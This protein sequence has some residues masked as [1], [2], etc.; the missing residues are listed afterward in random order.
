MTILLVG[1]RSRPI[2]GQS[3]CFNFLVDNVSCKNY[4]VFTTGRFSSFFYLMDVI[5]ISF[6]KKIDVVYFT[7]S[8]SKL[9]F[10]RDLY[11]I[12]FFYLRKTKVVNHLHGA[13]FY[14]F[15]FSSNKIF[16]YLINWAYK[17]I[18]I[19]IV[20][21]EGMKNQY[22]MFPD[23]DIRVVSNFYC[24]ED[25]G[26]LQEVSSNIRILFL[27]NLM[28][29]KGLIELVNAFIKASK[30]NQKIELHIAGSCLGN[31]KM[32]QYVNS[33]DSDKVHFHGPVEGVVKCRL[34]T[35]S[36]VVALPTYYPTEAQ[37][38]AL[39]EGMASG[40][41]VLTTNH[42][43][44]PEFISS[45]NG[46]LVNVDNLESNIYNVLYSLSPDFFEVENV[47][48]NNITYA[49]DFFSE[50]VHLQKIKEIIG[51]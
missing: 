47:M 35:Q 15:Y 8:R 3:K 21:T 49:Q 7:S 1:P 19:S 22:S 44:L 34:L 51:A 28:K 18:D 27:S 23:M 5:R 20:L 39:I 10:L 31:D 6:F 40:C 24:D 29:E 14:D 36:H 25:V 2:T 50:I 43:Y 38:L 30:V 48:G 32:L 26:G 33:I 17:R 41:A 16:R 45:D 4:K 46:F 37:P 9:G 42:N 11:L 12:F 13:D